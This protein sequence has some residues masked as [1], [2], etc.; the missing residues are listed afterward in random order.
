MKWLMARTLR[1]SVAK[2][3]LALYRT[4]FIGAH[5]VPATGALI[6]ANHVSYLDPVLLWCGATRPIHFM[7]KADLWTVPVVGW[8]LPRLWAIP[9]RRG[10]PDRS[11]ISNATTLLQEGE[12]VG[13]FPEGTRHRVADDSLGTQKR[14]EPY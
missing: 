6:A 14:G 3:V 12:L 11:A 8:V 4:R 1:A 5:H 2:L 9:V 10:E 7:A 13:I